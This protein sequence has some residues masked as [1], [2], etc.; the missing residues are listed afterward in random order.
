MEGAWKCSYFEETRNPLPNPM[1]RAQR[2]KRPAEAWG[3]PVPGRRASRHPGGSRRHGASRRRPGHQEFGSLME[4][5]VSIV[6]VVRPAAFEYL[7]GTHIIMFKAAIEFWKSGSLGRQPET[8]KGIKLGGC[9]RKQGVG[10]IN[11]HTSSWFVGHEG[12]AVA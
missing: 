7:G 9:L 1:S 12:C 10:R 8:Q 6:G 4:P 5:G 2:W 11:R 3:L